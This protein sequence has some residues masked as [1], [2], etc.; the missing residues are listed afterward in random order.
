MSE[1][2]WRRRLLAT[3]AAMLLVVGAC[4]NNDGGGATVAP[5][6]E[7]PDAASPAASAGGESPAASG[8]G[9]GTGAFQP[10]ANNVE[11]T[12]WNPFT[13]PDGNFFSKIVDDFNAATPTVKVTVQTQPGAE[14]VQRLE[15]AAAANQLPHVIAAGYDVLPLLTENGITVAIDEF[16]QTGGYDA[17]MFP[18]A[19]WNAGQWKDQRVGVPIDTH[20][21][22]LY[23]NKKL[24][25]D[26]G[27]DPEAP[28]TDQ[29]SFEAA[30]TAINEKTDADGLQMVSSGPGANFLV[31]IL[32]ASLFYQGG[33]EWTN[34]DYTEATFNSDAG[35]QASQYLVKLVNE[36]KVPTVESDAE[37]N[38]FTQG[39]NAMMFNGIWQLSAAQDAL[40]DDLGVA[41]TPNFFGEGTWGGT[42]NLAVTS[43]AADGDLK[44]A[45]YYFIDW[46]SQN[47][48][49]WGAAGQIPARNDVRAQVTAGGEGLLDLVAQVVP[50]ADT[51][52]FL[53]SIPGGGDLLFI[54]NGAGEAATLAINGSD[55]KQTLDA[56]AT[57]NSDVLKQNKERYGY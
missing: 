23:Y 50:L 47:S 27:L 10:P 21:M 8:D 17:S 57:F 43:A 42:H 19:I 16:A 46:F 40:G 18:E 35:V 30:I 29:A 44:Q 12:V 28:P 48:L 37:L 52:R 24:F 38:A 53:P 13:G 14:Y 51:V 56:A 55:P 5:G 41:P 9:A 20:P 25:T 36:L 1:L 15:A 3:S 33:G 49:N 6:G 7:S 22:I 4:G 39:K 45:A 54:A 32:W 31:G 26:A 11:L 34:A 2:T